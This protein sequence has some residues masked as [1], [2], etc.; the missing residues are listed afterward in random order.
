MKLLCVVV[1]VISGFAYIRCS[2]A[3][4]RKLNDVPYKNHR[5][6]TSSRNETRDKT[7]PVYAAQ[8]YA[9]LSNVKEFTVAGQSATV[10]EQ[11]TKP[12]EEAPV[13]SLQ[14]VVRVYITPT[15]TVVAPKRKSEPQNVPTTTQPSTPNVTPAALRTSSS[16][17]H[18]IIFVTSS[19]SYGS[20]EQRH[21]SAPASSTNQHFL[22]ATT[23]QLSSLPQQSVAVGSSNKASLQSSGNASKPFTTV[24]VPKQ[25]LDGGGDSATAAAVGYNGAR[26]DPFRPIAAPSFSYAMQNTNTQLQQEPLNR[27]IS[28][29]VLQS[30]RSVVRS[31]PSVAYRVQ[32][33]HKP[34]DKIDQYPLQQ[35]KPLQQPQ[36]AVMRKYVEIT[37]SSEPVVNNNRYNKTAPSRIPSPSLQ[38]PSIR[39]T[40]DQQQPVR[41]YLP[42]TRLPPPALLYSPPGKLQ[43]ESDKLTGLYSD[44][45]KEL[46]DPVTTPVWFTSAKS[47]TPPLQ[48]EDDVSAKDVLKSLLH[49]LLKFKQRKP[50]VGG[51]EVIESYYKNNNRANVEEDFGLDDYD[52]NTGEYINRLLF[53]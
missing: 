3:E 20:R 9:D 41:E 30:N 14:D 24:L 4:S 40:V 19:Q 52:I 5:I 45:V 36:E 46:P 29:Y 12:T 42:A 23:T 17:A 32:E 11:P 37:T 16:A 49:D 28:P 18:P 48:S 39:M 31:K 53:S 15:P 22:Y 38:S 13:S 34:W 43:Y 26:D 35:A 33:E 21:K 8:M 2:D 51:D 1:M 25:M 50:S 6:T 44:N 47:S 10:G 7:Y 27:R